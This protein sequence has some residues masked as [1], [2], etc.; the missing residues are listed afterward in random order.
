MKQFLTLILLV[1][2]SLGMHSAWGQCSDLFF[3]EYIEGSSSNKALEIYNPTGSAISLSDYVIYRFNN[4]SSTA[5]DSLFPGGSVSSIGA[6]DVYVIGNSSADPAI[7]AES[8]TTH[9]MTFY[10]GDDAIVLIKISTGD[11]L[12]I[13]G[14]VGVDPGSSWTVGTGATRDFTLVRM[15]GVDAGTTDWTVGETQWNVEP[16]NTYSFLGSHG[17]TCDPSFVPVYPIG[18]VT[19]D[20][21]ND[22]VGDS[23]GVS[24]EL[25]GV[26]HGI[27][28]QGGSSIQFTFI[29]G[30]GG[31]GL[32][33][34]NDY[35]YTVQEG[36]S[37]HIPCTI[38]QFNGLTQANP[39][40][41]ILIS[42][43]NALQTPTTITSLDETTESELI[44]FESAYLVNPADWPTSTGST[45]F[46]ITNGTDTITVRVDSDTDIDGTPG[47]V[48]DTFNIVGLGGQFDSSS[49]Y[50]DGYQ[51]L[52]RSL[53]D[54]EAD[55]TEIFVSGLP[56]YDIGVVTADNDG[57]G[58]G[59]SLGVACQLTGIVHG[60]DLSG[61]SSVSFTI[62]DATGGIGVFSSN[63]YGYTVQEGDSV[64]VPGTI[65]QF[66]GLTQVN[67]DTIVLVSS[68]NDLVTPTVIT[69]LGESTESELIRF[70]DAYLVTP[71]Q[72]PTSTGSAN[73][74]ITNGTDTILVRIDSDTDIDGTPAPTDTFDIIGI[75]G[76]FD[77]SSPY[78]DGY[79]LL[80]RYQP[81]I[82][83]DTTG[84]MGLPVY[85]IGLVT[86]D[87]SGDG[88]GDSLG[89]ACELRGVVYGIDIQGGSNISFTFID[90][91]GGIGLFSSNDYGYTVQEGDS[92]HIPGTI[93]QFN[94]L[95]QMNPD[96]I[97]L[98]SSGNALADTHCHH[99]F[100]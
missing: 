97:F 74:D 27:D 92:V 57:D 28:L 24:C 64:V 35:G 79:Q 89:V 18:L 11:T 38:S 5:T 16:Q 8:D 30:T 95:T 20:N 66:N 9:S 99:C 52:P 10:N 50:L 85:P 93:G 3:S 15:A 32:F 69:S 58:V 25:R 87:S 42:S 59:D 63:D 54:I 80:P 1:G 51:L 88:V 34:S 36:D 4:G 82:L 40:T 67:P 48:A 53:M 7:L 81:D 41:I 33:S 84:F 96:T 14:V 61:G 37:V 73:V 46:D 55:T 21:D 71:S 60:I 2:M 65:S 13:I 6:Y 43:G 45:N 22:G 29:D 70:N 44:R 12:D 90:A 86:A 83:Q 17:S 39:D 56:P 78:N 31:I 91:T 76:Q 19:A 100:G 26:V 47:P 23:L 94:G 98:I 49:P 77:S 68:G 72:W 75:G 62:I